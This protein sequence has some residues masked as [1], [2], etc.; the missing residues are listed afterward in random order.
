MAY[1]HILTLMKLA[2]SHISTLFLS[3]ISALGFSQNKTPNVIFI[4]ADDLGYS[5]IQP[6][7]Q[8]KILT[9]NLNAMARN[10]MQFM[11]FYAGTS[12]SAPS[13]AS[14]MTG[15]HT[16]HT[17]VRGNKEYA[18]EGQE[19]LGTDKTL[20]DLFQSAGYVTGCFGK[21]GLGFPSSGAETTDKGFDVFYGY[22]C[23]RQAHTYYPQW[24][25]SNKTKVMLDG[26]QYSQDL[27]HQQALKFIRDNKDRPFFG[28]FTYTL[29]HAGLEQPNDSIVAMY[30]GKFPE[31]KA[32]KGNGSYKATDEPRTQFAAMV[33]RL[34]A[35]VGEIRAELERLGIA[36]NTLL[37]F[38]S[39]NGPH[40]E[41]GAD[42][43]FFANAQTLRGLKRSLYEGGIRVPMIAE[44]K[45][46]VKSGIKTNFPAT[47]WDMTPTFAQLTGQT[48]TWKQ[49]SDGVS[50]LPTLTGK[51]LQKKHAYFYWEFHEEGGRQAIRQG[52]WK[53]IK[54][55]IKSG[56]PTYELYN[57][58][59]DSFEKNNVADKN[60]ARVEK[61]KKEM[62]KVRVPSAMFN[63]GLED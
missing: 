45:G 63:F 14:L 27:I 58:K 42:P 41:G 25:Y 12:V 16:G 60:S 5:D 55:K 11:Q 36:E 34:D 59:N 13:R 35:Y 3:A 4:L 39:D 28:Y 40:M 2:H 62:E 54:Q 24:L 57:L 9:P 53:L 52:D 51:G 20:G 15:L 43:A 38:T 18:P 48:K 17:H 61:M 32:Y 8:E 50:I 1:W 22:N 29:P 6:Y 47:F 46:K 44:W 23:Q 31:P 10:G 49:H 7:G 56:N 30:R 33:T 26:K 19:P 37:I 21:W